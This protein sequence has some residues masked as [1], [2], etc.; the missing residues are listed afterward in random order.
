[1][2]PVRHKFDDVVKAKEAPK[3]KFASQKTLHVD[4]VEED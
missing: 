2:E 1:M 4:S 3:K